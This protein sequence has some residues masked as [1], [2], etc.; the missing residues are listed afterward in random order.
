[1]CS[2]RNSQEKDVKI[3]STECIIYLLKYSNI[4]KQAIEY[5]KYCLFNS[6]WEIRYTIVNKKSFIKKYSRSF[7][8]EIENEAK[9]DNNYL[10]RNLLNN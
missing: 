4:R 6:S 10:I 1:M 5:L 8:V 9:N 2:F 7:V 3:S